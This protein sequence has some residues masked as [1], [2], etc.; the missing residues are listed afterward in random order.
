MDW[1]IQRR[2]VLWNYGQ[3]GI[4]IGGVYSLDGTPYVVGD[5]SVSQTMVHRRIWA[6]VFSIPDADSY[7]QY[8]AAVIVTNPDA[9]RRIAAWTTRVNQGLLDV[10]GTANQSDNE[11]FLTDSPPFDV[12]EDAFRDTDKCNLPNSSLGARV[13]SFQVASKNVDQ[14]LR[15]VYRCTMWPILLTSACSRIRLEVSRFG[16]QNS[17]PYN[18]LIGNTGASFTGYLAGALIV[19]SQLRPFS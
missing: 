11:G 8:D 12:V 14:S 15:R 17:N 1:N 16:G 19:Q 5:F 9:E 13:L 7:P 3:L 18:A 10:P 4:P 6:A 2:T